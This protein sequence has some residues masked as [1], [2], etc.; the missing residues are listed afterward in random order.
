M[1]QTPMKLDLRNRIHQTIEDV[2][3]EGCSDHIHDVEIGGGYLMR[4]GDVE[5]ATHNGHE[6]YWVD[7]RVFL[8]KDSLR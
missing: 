3:Y 7:M 6:G 2:M 1:S 8:R 5:E 4:C